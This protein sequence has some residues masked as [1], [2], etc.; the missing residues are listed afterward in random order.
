MAKSFSKSTVGIMN[1]KWPA[2]LTVPSV[3]YDT[4]VSHSFIICERLVSLI[5]HCMAHTLIWK[6]VPKI[7]FY[8]VIN[9]AKYIIIELLGLLRNKENIGNRRNRA[10]RYKY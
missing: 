8:V 6:V 4:D 3:Q 10:I 5:L 7:C 9:E 1:V 2:G